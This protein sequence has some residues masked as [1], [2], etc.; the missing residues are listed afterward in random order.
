MEQQHLHQ[1]FTAAV[2]PSV[3]YAEAVMNG[4]RVV[5]VTAW[6]G[7]NITYPIGQEHDYP[8]YA[9]GQ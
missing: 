7:E 5:T 9:L 6:S 8:G 4:E 2:D 1:N 3:V